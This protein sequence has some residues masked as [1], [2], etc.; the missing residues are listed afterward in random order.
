MGNTA[1]RPLNDRTYDLRKTAAARPGPPGKP[2]VIPDA[3][4][5]I[6]PKK[7][8]DVVNLKWTPPRYLGGFHLTGYLVERRELGSAGVGPGVWVRANAVLAR[9]PRL[10]VASLEPG[11]RYQFR[12]SAENAAGLMSE[13]SPPSE[14]LAVGYQGGV[15]TPPRFLTTLSDTTAIEDKR[16]DFVVDLTGTPAPSICWYKDSNEIFS[17]RRTRVATGSGRTSLTF[18]QVGLADEGEIRCTATNKAGHAVTKAMLRVEARPRLRLPRTLSPASS[19][20]SSVDEEG[21]LFHLDEVIKL[22]VGVTGRPQPEVT[23]YHNGEKLTSGVKDRV[24]ITDSGKYS[25]LRILAA[26][27]SDRGEYRVTA[28]NV[29]GQDTASFLVTVTDRPMPPSKVDVQLV[30]VGETGSKENEEDVGSEEAKPSSRYYLRVSWSP[31]DDDGG[32]RV[33]SYIIE[34]YRIGW[35]VWLKGSTSRQIS[36]S[37]DNL[38]AGSE[39]KFRVKA[40]NPY[41]VSDPSP[42]SDTI[43][44]PDPKRGLMHPPE[45]GLAPADS[46]WLLE[47]ERLQEREERMEEEEQRE[48]RK[49]EDDGW[50]DPQRRRRLDFSPSPGLSPIPSPTWGGNTSPRSDFS[51]DKE[52]PFLTGDDTDAGRKASNA[53]DSSNVGA[54]GTE[55]MLVLVPPKETDKQQEENDYLDYRRQSSVSEGPRELLSMEDGEGEEEEDVPMAPPMSLSAP[56][57]SGMEGDGSD[58]AAT[59]T[60]PPL[61]NAVSSSELLHERAMAR[62]Y[63]DAADEEAAAAS[64]RRGSAGASLIRRG[65]SSSRRGSTKDKENWREL[66]ER[67]KAEEKGEIIKEE[68]PVEDETEEKEEVDEKVEVEKEEKDEN[69]FIRKTEE[70]QDQVEEGEEYE[71]EE[72]EEEEEEM[73]EYDEEEEFRRIEERDRKRAEAIRRQEL[74]LA[75]SEERGGGLS[76]GAGG[77]SGRMVAAREL[78]QPSSSFPSSTPSRGHAPSAMTTYR[79]P[80]PPRK[81]VHVPEDSGDVTYRKVPTTRPPV[82]ALHIS[83]IDDDT[84]DGKALDPTSVVIGHYGDIIREVSSRV[85]RASP[86]LYL[87]REELKAQVEEDFDPF[88][89]GFLVGETEVERALEV[90]DQ[91]PVEPV[92][93]EVIVEEKV[94]EELESE[95]ASSNVPEDHP[96][97]CPEAEEVPEEVDSPDV[98]PVSPPTP[99]PPPRVLTPWEKSVEERV[100]LIIDSLTTT[101][102]LGVAS[103]LLMNGWDLTAAALV[104]LIAAKELY[105]ALIRRFPFLRRT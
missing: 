20:G 3:S 17:T 14:P 99:P 105:K 78:P 16:I 63:Q 103:W 59:M 87:S 4:L 60:L 2:E 7:G 1:A 83:T 95:V 58:Y 29:H 81:T 24:E 92:E 91:K 44:L 5:G 77:R 69:E 23:W 40:E 31:P 62:I 98:V 42:V 28:V 27:R 19:I 89:H 22:R 41:G 67:I 102:L 74:E 9:A 71:E 56:V 104:G 80:S 46:E 94:E 68:E 84:D 43:F 45:R 79:K 8:R 38:I 85:R 90:G 51:T 37:M 72:E 49:R 35:N 75:D 66:G 54:D 13:P 73:D 50:R 57:I 36:L 39:Y 47:Q 64:A 101:C 100:H 61:R 86:T 53:K 32:C 25:S 97:K 30:Q 6:D 82:P 11:R 93:E 15:A 55:F 52:G 76:F 21:L 12:V 10:A 88:E 96:V 34:Y 48:K 26:K 33:G 70:S 18:H 65:S